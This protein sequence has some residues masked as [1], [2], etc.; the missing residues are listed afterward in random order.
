LGKES[1]V[2]GMSKNVRAFKKRLKA[3]IVFRAAFVTLLLGSSFIFKAGYEKFPHPH[4]LSYLIIFL[5]VLTVT[6]SLLLEKIKRLFAFAY[7]QLVV[8]V[9]LGVTLI[10]ITGGIESWFSFTL[11]LTVISSSIVLNKRAGYIT[12]TLSS[13]LYGTLINFQFQRLLLSNTGH[14]MEAKDYF[15]NIFI[16]IVSFYLTAYLSGYLSSGLEKAARK[17][18]EKATDFRDLEF[19]NL[20]V[21]ES[22][23]SGLFTTDTSGSVLIFNRAAERITGCKKDSV[24]GRRINEVLPIFKPIGGRSEEVMMVEGFQRVIGFQITPLK[25]ISGNNTGFIGIFQDL[26]ELKRFEAEVKRKEKWAAIGELSSNIAHEIRNPLASL[27][28]SIEMLQDGTI[29]NDHRKRLMEIALKEMECLN[30]IITDFLTYSRPTPPEFQ[31]FEL[32]SILD[33]TTELLKHAEQNRGNIS[34]EKKYAGRLEVNADPQKLRQVFWNLGINAIEAM[35]DGGEL[36]VSTRNT[37]KTVEITFKDSGA[38]IDK[39]NMERIFYPFF[40]TK[41]NGTGLGLSIAY[42]IIE[43]HA[44]RINVESNPGIGTTFEVILPKTDGKV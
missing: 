37:D 19:F 22:L 41:D 9:I 42:R 27:K 12:A 3:L 23:P 11:V 32:H 10:Y 15:Y 26:T 39:H 24:I 30:R 16:H 17:L 20:E 40:T 36:L 5:Y 8:D 6:Y 1:K 43:E 7:A 29:P 25:D 28:G 38:G 34:I 35:P 33:E 2:K 44:G 13:I 31:R 4:A 21:I 18:D 14:I